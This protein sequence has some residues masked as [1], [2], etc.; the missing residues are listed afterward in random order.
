MARTLKITVRLSDI[1]NEVIREIANKNQ[2]T[3]SEYIRT[4]VFIK[5]PKYNPECNG[6][7]TTAPLH[8]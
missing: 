1:E 4:L 6:A 7:T 5:E 8:Q 3:I 2:I